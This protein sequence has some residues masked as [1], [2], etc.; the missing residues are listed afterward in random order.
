MRFGVWDDVRGLEV[1]GKFGGAEVM[2]R[3]EESPWAFEGEYGEDCSS[4]RSVE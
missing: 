1:S 4:S 3:E 2:A